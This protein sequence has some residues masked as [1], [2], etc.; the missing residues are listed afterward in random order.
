MLGT[1]TI[2]FQSLAEPGH[3]IGD[4]IAIDHPTFGG[5][6]EETGWYIELKEGSMMKHTAKRAVIA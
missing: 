6:Y 5:I 3:G 2:T 1:K 4:V